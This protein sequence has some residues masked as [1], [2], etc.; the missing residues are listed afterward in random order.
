MK[1]QLLTTTALVA[2]GALATAS[3]ASAVQL[4][5]GGY[6]EGIIGVADDDRPFTAGGD[7]GTGFDVQQDGEIHFKSATTLD[8]GLK[9]RTRLELEGFS[10]APGATTNGDEIDEAYIAISGKWGE[11]RIGSED[12][13]AHLMVTP[14]MGSWA[15]NVGQNLNFDVTDWLARPSGHKGAGFSRMQVGEGDAEKITY[16]TPRVGGFQDGVSY[17]PSGDEDNQSVSTATVDIVNGWAVGTN[18]RAKFSNVGVGLAAGYAEAQPA[19]GTA[20]TLVAPSDP[21]GYSASGKISF[22]GVT[23]AAGYVRFVNRDGPTTT[24]NGGNALDLGA[25]YDFGKNHVSI[26][27]VRNES[28]ADRAVAGEDESDRMLIS[29][30]RDLGPGIQYR[31]NFHYA[32]FQGENAGSADDNEGV[33]V[34]TSVRLAF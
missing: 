1:K 6:M 12:N 25:K 21:K 4:K 26:G 9:I 13:A 27:Y 20:G 34:S 23:L 31:L 5:V 2:A 16:F 7:P 29:Y 17:M 15:T 11:V 19:Q 18:Y 24:D 28:E 32:D 14:T 8:N 30:R 10:N 3:T 22:S 33:A